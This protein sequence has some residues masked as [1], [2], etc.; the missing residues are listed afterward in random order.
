MTG[1]NPYLLRK[2]VYP[3]YRALKRDDVL[4]YL[5]EMHRV[6]VM[7]P[8]EIRAFQ[9]G[10]LK[11]LI[12]HAAVNVPYY[13]RV[14]SDLGAEPGDFKSPDDLRSLPVLRKSDVREN[15]EDLIA[16]GYPRSHLSHDETGGSTGQ[17]L[18]FYTDRASSEARRANNVRMNEWID[19]EIGDRWAFLW[20]VRFRV[21]G[22]ARV[23]A[24]VRNWLTN[25]MVMSAYKMDETSV[26]SYMARL[27]RFKPDVMMGYPSAL[28]HLSLTIREAGLESA[29][30]G[31]ILVSGETL[32]GWQRDLIE[33]TFGARV[34]NHYG[35]CEFGALAR[36][37]GRRDGLHLACERVLMEAV[38]VERTAEGEE[39]KE[40]IMTDLDDYGMPFIRYAL[41]DHG[42]LD[43]EPC[44]CGIN[45]PRLRSML[46]R[47]YDL[48]RAP[49]GNV[50]GGTFWGHLLKENVEKFQVVQ[51]EIDLIRIAIVPDGEFGERHRKQA[52]ERIR[53]AC[54]DQ[55]RVEFE[56]KSDIET[57]R[58]GKHR[59]IISNLARRSEGRP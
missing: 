48:V 16:D 46:G 32:Y 27:A 42:D 12:E 4:R 9:W 11:R 6:Q 55:I 50:L 58:S 28:A 14:F 21:T 53:Q 40:I 35:C 57:T 47:T 54:G 23:K 30:P 49:N 38:P 51:D 18:F 20:G 25:T 59:Y 8:E 39:V 24:A 43:W 33:A 19:V 3:A 7:E 36:E 2:I 45:L 26:R 10:K 52:L 34:Y 44:G 31:L 1:M 13:R 56:I 37:C 41:E 29:Q 22:R 5:D 15:L 17:N